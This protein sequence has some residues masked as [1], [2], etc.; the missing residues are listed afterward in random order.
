MSGFIKLHRRIMDNPLFQQKPAARHLFIDLLS[1][2]A[3][4]DTTQD[5]R[6]KPVAIARGQVMISTRSVA[7]MCGF[8]HQAVRT[9]LKQ[10]ASHEVVKINTLPNNG[11]M[12]ITI[13]N[14]SKYQDEQHT[15]NTV[16]NTPLTHCQHTKERR[17]EDKKELTLIEPQAPK[18]DVFEDFWKAYPKKVGKGQAERAFRA[19]LKITSLE[20]ILEAIGE[21]RGGLSADKQFIPHPSSW[22][23]GKRWLDEKPVG[24]VNGSNM[25]DAER[26][27]LLRELPNQIDMRKVEIVGN[28]T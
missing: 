24:T 14:Y 11:P 28:Y 7:D 10:L 19:A 13:C 18:R 6:G 15:A 8:G 27:W 16:A 22:L 1:L 2:A 12:V 17:E 23:N 25:S 21:Q 5:W 4:K 20:T 26:K 3:W 9:I